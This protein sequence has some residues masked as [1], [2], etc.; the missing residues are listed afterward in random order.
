MSNILKEQRFLSRICDCLK[1]AA[2]LTEV[3]S[4]MPNSLV[5]SHHAYNLNRCYIDANNDADAKATYLGTRSNTSHASGLAKNTVKTYQ[6]DLRRLDLYLDG[7]SYNTMSL[8]DVYA[9]IDWLKHP[10][11]DLIANMR[12]PFASEHWRP[13][14]KKGLSGSSLNQQLI[15]CKAFFAWMNKVGYLKANVFVLARKQPVERASNPT[16]RIL[17]AE[18]LKAIED[19][20]CHTQVTGTSSKAQRQ[21]SI[22]ARWRFLYYCYINT[23]LRLSEI[24]H[25]STQHIHAVKNNNTQF[26]TLHIRG[27]GRAFTDTADVIPLN[28]QFI[29]ELFAYRTFLGKDNNLFNVDEPL[30]YSLSGSHAVTSRAQIH[31]IMKELLSSVAHVQKNQGNLES[32]SRLEQSSTHWFRHSFVTKVV[33]VSADIHAAAK[34]ARHRKIETTMMYDHKEL[35]RLDDIVN[36]LS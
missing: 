28:T 26:Y 9:F 34:L 25:L 18:D 14:Y 32:A 27:K 33:N 10:P 3:T 31:N 29:Q 23:G 5:D 11:V 17:L 15:S 2:K 22:I 7:K 36:Q 12:H 1:S 8:D 24:L 20:L 35:G 21:R 6:R 4:T 19:Y 13:F 16:E 30:L